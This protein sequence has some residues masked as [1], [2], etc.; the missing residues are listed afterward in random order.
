MKTKQILPLLLLFI[1]SNAFGQ[2]L[3]KIKGSKVVI[4]TTKN[5][6]PFHTINMGQDIELNLVKAELPSLEIEADDNLH[7]TVMCTVVDSVLKIERIKE[8]TRSKKYKLRI[9][10]TNSLNK[11]VLYDEAKLIATN[12]IELKKLNI[13]CSEKSKAFLNLNIDEFKIDFKDKS[14]AELNIT[15]KSSTLLLSDE[16]KLKALIVS[17][18]IKIDLLQKAEATIEGESLYALI[19]ID[20]TTELMAKNFSVTNLT[21]KTV[22]E[23]EAAVNAKNLTLSAG[24]TTETNLYGDCKIEIENFSGNAILAKKEFKVK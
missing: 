20:N 5:I 15:S 24:D 3:E 22:N 18:E 8:I 4:I 1:F 23:A 17:P 19:R 9:N 12:K 11:I 7:E 13:N 2:K 16:S 14:K 10:Y 6:P 21:L